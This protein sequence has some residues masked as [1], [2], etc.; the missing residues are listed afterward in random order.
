[1]SFA[2][3]L[4]ALA[5]QRELRSSGT[6]HQKSLAL[7]SSSFIR[8]HPL[9]DLSSA[10]FTT[11]ALGEARVRTVRVAQHS[12]AMDE[13]AEG[14]ASVLENDLR[15]VRN[16]IEHLERSTRELHAILKAEPD[17]ADYRQALSENFE[18]LRVKKKRAD[19]L[20]R[21]LDQATGRHTVNRKT[22]AEGVHL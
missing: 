7:K 4:L 12:A 19:D 8:F 18:A 6:A 21:A 5:A 15:E 2:A 17:D 14:N 1:M 11:I 3:A 9:L 10:R 22:P 16:S 20:H 13:I